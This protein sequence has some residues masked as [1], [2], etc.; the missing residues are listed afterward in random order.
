MGVRHDKDAGLVNAR[1]AGR[2]AYYRDTVVTFTLTP[3]ASGTR[4][5]LLCCRASSHTRS[6]TSAARATAGR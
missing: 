1:R 5:S 2:C 3:T 6:R 4:L